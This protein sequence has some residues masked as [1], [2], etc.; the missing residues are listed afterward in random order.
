VSISTLFYSSQLPL[1]KILWLKSEWRKHMES[2]QQS[3][4]IIKRIASFSRSK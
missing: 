3:F 2:T 4:W 1:K